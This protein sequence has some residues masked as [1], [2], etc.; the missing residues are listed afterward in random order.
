[1]HAITRNTVR[2]DESYRFNYIVFFVDD[3]ES[4]KIVFNCSVERYRKTRHE[5]LLCLVSND[6]EKIYFVDNVAFKQ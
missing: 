2:A 4:V 3:L 6:C 1:M 5:L